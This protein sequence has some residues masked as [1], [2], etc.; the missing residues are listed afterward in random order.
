MA[1]E[2]PQFSNA[3]KYLLRLASFHAWRLTLVKEV[4]HPNLFHFLI[5]YIL[6][7]ES[8]CA[9]STR[10][11]HQPSKGYGLSLPF[12]TFVAVVAFTV[13]D[14]CQELLKLCSTLSCALLCQPF[15]DEF[16]FI[17]AP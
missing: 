1:T 16:S 10:F 2:Q 8:D 12:D 15:L 13:G 6:F 3:H 9:I 17:F 14:E 7:T 4:Q 5:C 11:L